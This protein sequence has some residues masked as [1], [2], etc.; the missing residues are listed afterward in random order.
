MVIKHHL[1]FKEYNIP[2]KAAMVHNN[3]DFFFFTEDANKQSS[4]DITSE[5]L[6]LVLVM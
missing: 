6:P 1:M 4:A 2:R 3:R 5:C